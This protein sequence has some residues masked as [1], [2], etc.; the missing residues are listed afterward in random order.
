MR[1]FTIGIAAAFIAA[2]VVAPA[3]A[4]GMAPTYVSS[5]PSDGEELHRAPERVEV[6]FSEPLDE[7]SD[8]TVSDSCG[9]RVDDGSP[10]V[11]GNTISV[12][13]ALEPSGHYQ[14]AYSATGLAGLT[15]TT[16]GSFHFMV[17]F[18]KACGGD[19]G[20]GH[21]NHGGN[22]TGGGGGGGGGG[23]GQHGGGGGDGDDHEGGDGH[24][25]AGHG[26]SGAGGA[27]THP[28]GHMSSSTHDPETS[29]HEGGHGERHRNKG[30]GKGQ[31]KH[32]GHEK[33]ADPKTD[34]PDE[35]GPLASGDGQPVAPDGTAVMLALGLSLLLG[36]IGG[37]FLRVSGAR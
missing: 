1:R 13:I 11:D 21:Q 33:A 14:V 20:G 5:E 23:H 7:S 26:S 19:G 37:W 17:H 12:G 28:G 34:D 24:S 30:H 35:P 4:A 36:T 22:G 25:G 31:G 10:T 6:T 15:G 27:S 29:G 16:K 2:L 3:S 32:K 8:L 9:R 18:G